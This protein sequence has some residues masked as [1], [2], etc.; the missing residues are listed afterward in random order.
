LKIP[1][2]LP[3]IISDQQL[4]TYFRWWLSP[5]GPKRSR[6]KLH[7]SKWIAV[8]VLVGA[9]VAVW[10]TGSA[11]AEGLVMI[12]HVPSGDPLAAQTL[13]IGAPAAEAHLA[14]HPD[15]VRGSCEE[16]KN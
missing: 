16:R 12:C 13:V 8:I 11:K 9:A 5:I 10:V 14:N 2:W 15:D 7:M 6:R 3:I 1:S 4:A